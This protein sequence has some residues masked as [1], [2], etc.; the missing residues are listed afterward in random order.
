M[1]T[2]KR[3]IAICMVVLTVLTSVPMTN[4]SLVSKAFVLK[5][6][7]CSTVNSNIIEWS[8]KY[9]DLDRLSNNN[10][11]LV[12]VLEYHEKAADICLDTAVS[13]TFTLVPN[14]GSFS[15]IDW[16]WS[17]GLDAFQLG[18]FHAI[19][20]DAKRNTD[21]GKSLCEE[22]L[23]LYISNKN[24]KGKVTNPDI[25]YK[26]FLNFN[27]G[28]LYYNYGNGYYLTILDS[29][30][31]EHKDK[32]SYYSNKT[33]ELGLNAALKSISPMLD[34]MFPKLTTKFGNKRIYEIGDL[35]SVLSVAEW[36][37]V[38]SVIKDE[39][40]PNATMFKKGLTTY[41]KLADVLYNNSINTKKTSLT[42]SYEASPFYDTSKYK[43]SLQNVTLTGDQRKDLVNVA[44]SQVGYHEG[45]NHSQISGANSSGNKNYTEYGY[46][47]GYYAMGKNDGHF[48]A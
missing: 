1:K 46:W 16:L 5:D 13:L 23:Q 44:L 30:V 12:K 33:I 29:F 22:A 37:D 25:A 7:I 38:L 21:Y 47:F 34:D 10:K 27:M 40:N 43:E 26:I 31:E 39:F 11:K 42:M 15:W 4:L 6:D 14:Y 48:Y 41:K 8:S 35:Y 3:I 2:L 19:I 17:R 45:N 9:V 28:F 20:G 24:S 36:N 18:F 32:F